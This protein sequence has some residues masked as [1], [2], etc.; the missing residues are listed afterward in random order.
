MSQERCFSI[1][2]SQQTF[3]KKHQEA[4][5]KHQGA[6]SLYRVI[7]QH[8]KFGANVP[9]LPNRGQTRPRTEAVYSMVTE[10]FEHTRSILQESNGGA[11]YSL[12]LFGD[13][14]TVIWASV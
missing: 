9:A 1:L 3:Q 11:N 8:T 2:T 7:Q 10:S 5:P 13:S 4:G 6:A 12:V 14:V